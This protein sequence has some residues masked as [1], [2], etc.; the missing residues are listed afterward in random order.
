MNP[1]GRIG[2]SRPSYHD[3]RRA[4]RALDA[5]KMVAARLRGMRDARTVDQFV[6]L[7]SALK[8]DLEALNISTQ[9]L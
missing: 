3:K 1:Q 7:R 6:A 5:A 9:T 4:R 2:G 8:F